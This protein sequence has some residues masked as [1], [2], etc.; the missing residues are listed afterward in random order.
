MQRPDGVDRHNYRR[1]GYRRLT[2]GVYEP[3]QPA[4]GDKWQTRQV[5]WLSKVNAIMALYQKHDPVLYGPTAL[6]ALGVWL[7]NAVEDWDTVH[8][9]VRDKGQRRQ[10]S[11]V[12]AHCAQNCPPI[13]RLARD[14]PVLHPVDHWL[15]LSHATVDDMVE[16]GDGFLRRR[17]PLLS[18]TEMGQRLD[19]LSGTRN[20]KPARQAMK[21]V[22]PRTDSLY[23][24]RTR[25]TLVHGGLKTPTVNLEVWCPTIG[26]PYLLDMAYEE[27]LL[28]VEYDGLVHV[29]N[30]EQMEIDADRR[31]NLQDMGWL[32]IT[33]TAEQLRRPDD[34]VRSVQ[35]ALIFRTK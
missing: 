15:Q 8:I 4:D 18:I 12:V 34:L 23:E 28:A 19:Q 10:R 7:P 20:V 13:W 6:Q 17:H 33:V 11:D 30:R 24:T 31:R 9:L 29:G 14:L 22:R 5:K 25:L 21:L 2:W 1:L 35:N 32:V 27:A 3:E 16:V 26:A